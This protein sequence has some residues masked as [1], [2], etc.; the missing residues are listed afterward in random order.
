MT[1]SFSSLC[2]TSAICLTSLW[3]LIA[4]GIYVA[5][6][7]RDHDI[8]YLFEKFHWH[9]TGNIDV[10]ED[11]FYYLR[12]LSMETI[13]KSLLW[14]GFILDSAVCFIE[15]M[16][17][18]LKVQALPVY[19]YLHSVYRYLIYIICDIFIVLFYYD[20]KY[21]A[22]YSITLLVLYGFSRIGLAVV[23]CFVNKKFSNEVDGIIIPV[24]YAVGPTGNKSMA[25]A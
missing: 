12:V 21:Y 13:S 25:G 18:W 16:V 7:Q 8:D 22:W 2:I 9:E 11:D 23:M 1:R 6:M 10:E 3:I 5:K 19:F 14:L 17:V 4:L 15:F 24:A 20:A